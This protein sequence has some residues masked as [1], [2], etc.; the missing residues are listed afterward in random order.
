VF[1]LRGAN[2]AEPYVGKT[3]NLRKRL[4]RLLSTSEGHSKRLNLREQVRTIEYT[5][6]GSDFESGFLLYR[7]LRRIFPKSYSDRLRLRFAPLLKFIVDN[8]FPRVAVTTRIGSLRGDARYYGPFPTRVFAEKFANDSLDFFKLRRCTDDLNPDPAFPGCIYSEMK[9][10]LAPCFRGCTDV[11]YTAEVERVQSFFDSGGSSLMRE[12]E[13]ERDHASESLDFELAAGAHA[14]LDKVKS[15]A[16]ELPE[17]VRRIDQL[18]AVMI[19]PSS[20]P[21]SVTLFRIMAGMICEPIQF[22]ISAQTEST[23]KP[24]S[25]ER[26]IDDALVFV[27]PEK[28]ASAMEWMEHLALLKRWYYRTNKTGEMFFAENGELPLR[29]IVRGVSRIFRGEK[30]QPDLNEAA[31]EYWTLRGKEAEQQSGGE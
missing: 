22:H 1:V 23:D 26:R 8:R 25:M 4:Q 5:A 20:M 11:E 21:D 14:R 13:A 18:D 15:V 24:L 6:T 29:R 3:S 17:I 7:T 30:P 10:C 16:R 9:M 27:A 19:Q 12:I 31:R 2:E 28:P